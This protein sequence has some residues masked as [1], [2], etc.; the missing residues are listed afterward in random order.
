MAVK[1]VMTG[2]SYK[3]PGFSVSPTKGGG[4]PQSVWKVRPTSLMATVLTQCLQHN[5]CNDH[6][7]PGK[8]KCAGVPSCP[9]RPLS[10]VEGQVELSRPAPSAPCR[11]GLCCRVRGC[12]AWR[13][14]P[15]CVPPRAAPC[16]PVPPFPGTSPRV[17]SCPWQV[18]PAAPQ[19][20]PDGGDTLPWPRPPPILAFM[21]RDPRNGAL[22]APA[23]Q[24]W[25][26][27][28]GCGGREGGRE[29]AWHTYT[30]LSSH[31]STPFPLP[32]SYF[33]PAISTS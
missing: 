24:E 33:P 5:S 13:V 10:R 8:R 1:Q 12:A 16:R 11:P 32:H 29:G 19:G 20:H 7:V 17:S 25:R 2:R 23:A 30:S 26:W 4:Y 3:Q 9:R 15:G 22:T 14:V 31:R 18:V 27:L 6:Y 21:L 28:Q